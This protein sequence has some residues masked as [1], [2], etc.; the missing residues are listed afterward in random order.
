MR[1]IAIITPLLNEEKNIKI[2]Y[3]V[4]SRAVEGINCKFSFL[5][6]DDGS[7]DNSWKEIESLAKDKD[8]V[9][10]VKLARNFGS[11]TALLA[12]I[13]SSLKNSKNVAMVLTTIDLQNPPELVKE[14]VAKLQRDTRVVWGVRANREDKG[15]GSVFSGIYHHLVKKYALKNMPEGGVDFCLIDRKVAQDVVSSEEK[16]T[17]LFGL[18]LWLG[19]HQEFIP[20]VRK[21]I[22]GRVSRW[23]LHKKIKL[24]ID[25]FVS[26]S[27]APIWLVTYLGFSISFVGFLYGIL[28][29]YRRV[30]HDIQI[31]GWSSLMLL[32]LLLFGINFIML[33][34]LA[35]YLWRTLDSARKRPTYL[36]DKEINV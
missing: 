36:V 16:N 1:Q 3:E 5:F 20:Y 34:I 2:F 26:F 21:M 19:Y 24:V 22:P 30:I 17:S 29:I 4:M 6:V 28:I 12:G 23:S 25:T 10:A 14:M 13:N 15:L 8:N 18:I 31:E 27:Y 7:T 32:M 33:G 11:H 9:S 35:E